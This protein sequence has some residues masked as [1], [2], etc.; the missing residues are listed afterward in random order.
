MDVEFVGGPLDGELLEMALTPSAL[1]VFRMNGDTP[2][3]ISDS[4]YIFEV[5]LRRY[6]YTNESDRHRHPSTPRPLRT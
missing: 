6:C 3:R 5:R 1:I 2:E 4:D